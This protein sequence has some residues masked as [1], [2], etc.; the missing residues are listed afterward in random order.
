MLS[1]D[2][3]P[4]EFR[5]H[6]IEEGPRT[7]R[8]AAGLLANLSAK[9]GYSGTQAGH[10]IVQAGFHLRYSGVGARMYDQA[11]S[12]S[13]AFEDDA[14]FVYLSG[15][16]LTVVSAAA[17]IDLCAAALAA[18]AGRTQREPDLREVATTRAVLDSLTPAQQRW[19]VETHG[20]A[21]VDRLIDVRNALVHRHVPLSVMIGE[22]AAYTVRVGGR[23]EAVDPSHARHLAVDRF[24]ALGLLILDE[25]AS[26]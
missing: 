2:D 7:H 10:R 17:S 1:V 4:D 9:H 19:V 21:H 16:Q 8:F 5:G 22:S 3:I 18:L 12:L 25:L 6:R 24:V 11:P 20:S 13:V 23:E 15:F 14:Q 26:D